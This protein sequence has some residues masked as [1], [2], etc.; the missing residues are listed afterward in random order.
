MKITQVKTG[1]TNDGQV[2]VGLFDEDTVLG[3]I[4][5]DLDE[6]KALILNLTHALMA[7]SEIKNALNK[8]L[9]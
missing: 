8:R 7:A 4:P 6:A 3:N 2:C 5:L 1:F 9:N